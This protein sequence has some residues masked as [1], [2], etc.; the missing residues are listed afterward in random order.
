MRS[1]VLKVLDILG[2]KIILKRAISRLISSE[3]FPTYVNLKDIRKAHQKMTGL[4]EESPLLQPDGLN[5]WIRSENNKT[6]LKDFLSLRSC[7]FFFTKTQNII[8][9]PNAVQEQKLL[10]VTANTNFLEPLVNSLVDLKDQ[11]RFLDFSII[12]EGF[13]RSFMVQT[14]YS[15]DCNVVDV[16]R[17]LEKEY[18]FLYDLIEESNT[19]FIEW[20]N[21]P[22][23]FFSKY[24]PEKTIVIRCHSYEAFKAETHFIK[25]DAVK[26]IVFIAPHI[27]A[28]FKR[29]FAQP[30]N[31]KVDTRVIQN[32]HDPKF[33]AMQPV[34]A[35]YGKTLGLT[36]FGSVNKDP[37]FALNILECLI[38]ED[39][40]W[41]LHLAGSEWIT[42]RKTEFEYHK[43]FRNKLKELENNLVLDGFVDNMVQWY[44]Q[45]DYILST[46]HREGSHESIVEGIGMGCIPVIRKWAH[47]EEMN[48]SIDLFDT[49]PIF[50]NAKEMANYILE[51]QSGK[52]DHAALANLRKKLFGN[53]QK[54]S[55]FRKLLINE[56]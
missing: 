8:P 21:S 19:I 17:K 41:K 11:V 12:E 24:Y 46:S 4:F 1:I 2:I 25:F 51:T 47:F 54:T 6:H 16:R 50:N 28:V 45:V 49:Q 52:I 13:G 40:E 5:N 36:Q 37:L 32:F 38:Q 33:L 39:S 29:I 31:Y 56:G 34:R 27:E 42:P 15:D 53:K 44:S 7:N 55:E 26:T 23:I 10:F 22:A 3:R 20:M 14:L 30:L 35:K 9:N 43:N 18:P 48:I